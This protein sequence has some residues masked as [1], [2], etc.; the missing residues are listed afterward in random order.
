MIQVSAS[1]V[2]FNN[3]KEINGVLSSLIASSISREIEI[4]IVDN[5]SSD[6]TLQKVQQSFPDCKVL[7]QTKNLGYGSGHNQAIELIQSEYHA[8][9]NPDITFSANTISNLVAFMENHPDIVLCSPKILNTDGTEQ[10]LPKLRP[11]LKYLLG[12]FLENKGRMFKRWRQEFTLAD[13]EINEPL[14]IDFCSGC[15]MF[16]RTKALKKCGGF[17]DRYFMYFEDAD[18]TREIQ[19]YGKTLYNPDITVTHKWKRENRTL[20]GLSRQ[21]TSMF[22]YFLKWKLR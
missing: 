1:I 20:K 12:G 7:S 15:F 3:A 9:I 19:R 14:E 17:D 16:F 11:S 10:Y 21:I 18:L 8:V 5:N 2:T 4:Y 13:V 6:D 22:K